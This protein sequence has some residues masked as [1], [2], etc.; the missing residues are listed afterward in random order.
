MND[1]MFEE[2]GERL[3]PADQ[4]VSLPLRILAILSI[5]VGVATLAVA[6]IIIFLVAS[7][8]AAGVTFAA[9]A[10]ASTQA[11]VLYAVAILVHLV[12]SAHFVVFSVR[13]LMNKRRG[14]AL[15]TTVMMAVAGLNM[16]LVLMTAG[17][18]WNFAYA[19]G[20]MI[21]LIVM[22]S[23]LDPQ[24]ADERRLQRRL[25]QLED[26][27]D[28]EDGT[29][30]RDKSGK[31]YIKLNFFNI[32]WIFMV[33]CFLGW[34]MEM[35]VC[36]FLN[37][38][39]EDRTGMLWGP[40][41]PI[42]GFGA[43]FMTMAL[44]RFYKSNPIIVFLV[45]AV[46]GAGFEFAVSYFFQYAFGIMAW[47]YSNEFMNLQGRTDLFHAVCWGALGLVFI[48]WILPKLLALINRI[49]WNWR[50]AATA[51]AFVL[52]MINGMMTLMAFDCWCQRLKGQPQDTP[53]AQFFEQ[54]FDNDFMQQRFPTMSIDPNR[55]K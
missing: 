48:R 46:I 51:V 16:V 44:N 13:L 6:G 41:S 33:A 22:H 2:E 23:Y 20:V 53:V 9:T 36:P 50:Y 39:I 1:T 42:Y 17:V 26:K 7:A 49:P 35:L 18:G 54:N 32:F 11:L 29:L 15:Q 47:D 30:G 14:A 19:V 31:G 55:Q 8:V 4:K 25:H 38:R 34:C 24:L 40:L 21:F 37:G 27:A 3:N 45:S 5:V 12:L 10:E 52:M 28:A 43:L